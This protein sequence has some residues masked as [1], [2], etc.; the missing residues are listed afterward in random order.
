MGIYFNQ[1]NQIIFSLLH[2]V[3]NSI[4]TIVCD[5]YSMISYKY[6]SNIKGIQILN[7]FICYEVHTHECNPIYYMSDIIFVHVRLFIIYLCIL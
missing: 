4:L 3:F 1:K 6:Y 7:K 2:R 5:A